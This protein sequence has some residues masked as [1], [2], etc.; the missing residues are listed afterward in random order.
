MCV[1]LR[2]KF[3]VSSIIPT[4][5]RRGKTTTT[6][7]WTP[8]KLNQIRVKRNFLKLATYRVLFE[9]GETT[10]KLKNNVTYEVLFL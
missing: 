6:W 8:Q 1:Y 9:T 4:S 10:I 5:F 3:Q 2:I 7:K